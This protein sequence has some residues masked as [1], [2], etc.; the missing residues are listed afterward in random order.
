MFDANP[1]NDGN[2]LD[3]EAEKM[4]HN[5][6]ERPVIESDATG[7]TKFASLDIRFASG[8]EGLEA[9]R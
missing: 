3:P 7:W 8:I 5:E 6:I 2:W 1:E 4:L 9:A